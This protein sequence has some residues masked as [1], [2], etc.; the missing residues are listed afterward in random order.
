MGYDTAGR[1]AIYML[2][3]RQNTDASSAEGQRKQLQHSFWIQER[4]IDLMPLG[5]E[6]VTLM[7]DY[8]DKAKA[9]S[10]STS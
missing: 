9:S 3:S 4:A 2:P 5:V 8:S 6:T 1:P 10:F 7:I